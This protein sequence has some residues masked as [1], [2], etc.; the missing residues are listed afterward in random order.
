MRLDRVLSRA[1]MEVLAGSQ[2]I[3]DVADI[4]NDDSARWFACAGSRDCRG[5]FYLYNLLTPH[6]LQ[7]RH[8][9]F[10]SR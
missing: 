8:L 10:L 3:L 9:C 4:Y 5:T 7:F 2:E 1:N 6:G